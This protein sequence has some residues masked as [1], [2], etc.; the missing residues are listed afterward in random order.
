MFIECHVRC[1]SLLV[2]F[3]FCILDTFFQTEIHSAFPTEV[4]TADA[5]M[6]GCLYFA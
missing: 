6:F 5:V 2:F 4:I 1:F 3:L